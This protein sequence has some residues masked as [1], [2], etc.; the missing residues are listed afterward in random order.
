MDSSTVEDIDIDIPI[1]RIKRPHKK[2]RSG[3][4]TCKRRRVKVNMPVNTTEQRERM[5][6]CWPQCDEGRPCCNR[7]HLRRLECAYAIYKPAHGSG[8]REPGGLL[9]DA[10]SKSTS[11][12]LDGKS[13]TIIE[14]RGPA[15]VSETEL[16]KH[17]FAH[18]MQTFVE[19]SLSE[20]QSCAWRVFMPALALTSP[21]VHRGMLT[22]AAICSH[23]DSVV[24]ADPIRESSKYLEAAQAHGEIFVRE[25]LRKM[26]DMHQSESEAIIACSR[27]LCV[28]GF[29]FF[30]THRENGSTLR[31][32]TSWTWLGLL[33]GV[34]TTYTAIVNSGREIDETVAKDMIP[35]LLNDRGLHYPQEWQMGLVCKH[36]SSRFVEQ[37]KGERFIA[38]KSTLNT[39]WLCLESQKI[40]YLR[41]AIDI[42]ELVTEHAFSPH[43]QSLFRMMC[44]WPSKVPRGF[45]DC[46]VD[47]FQPALAIY[48]HWLML[49]VLLE[50]LWW[51]DD[52]GRSGIRNVAD[53]CTHAT[54]DVRSLLMW[55]QLMLKAEIF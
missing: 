10:E 25:S 44:T 21:V 15:Y 39:S 50:D 28:L 24:T 55:P 48:A 35:E 49:V 29:A 18:T 27:F 14:N 3:C 47:G 5:T 7:C 26:R 4:I 6:Y 19:T 9:N 42:L 2:T 1:L 53:M 52:M 43:V 40:E 31:D 22:L 46:L 11:S 36:P 32:S 34:R 17:Y 54:P 38:L 23:Y 16:A 33:R 30:R 41:A 12:S 13:S 20:D 45:V 37:S 51:I 8:K